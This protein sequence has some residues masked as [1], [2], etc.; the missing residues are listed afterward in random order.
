MRPRLFFAS[1]DDF[2]ANSSSEAVVI[3]FVCFL[4]PAASAFSCRHP[5]PAARKSIVRTALSM[6]IFLRLP[7]V[8]RCT[9]LS[10]PV[11]DLVNPFILLLM[12]RPFPYQVSTSLSFTFLIFVAMV[13][14]S[15]TCMNKL[16]VLS[17]FHA[18]GPLQTF[19]IRGCLRRF[20]T[21]LRNAFLPYRLCFFRKKRWSGQRSGLS[22]SFFL[23]LHK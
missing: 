3:T 1:S 4:L 20:D 18:L 14:R 5:T 12:Y 19:G 15:Q 11:P 8:R 2:S 17:R 7:A 23:L 13:S 6:N 10:F 21:N 16:R 22:S 9:E